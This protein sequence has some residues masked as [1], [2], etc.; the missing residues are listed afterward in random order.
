[1]PTF[2]RFLLPFAA[3]AGLGAALPGQGAAAATAPDRTMLPDAALVAIE[4]AD[5]PA[6]VEAMLSALGTLPED[7]PEGTRAQISLG[8]AGVAVALGATPTGWA[9]RVAGGGA[10]VGVMPHGSRQVVVA[11][12]RPGDLVEASSWFTRIVGN[13]HHEIVGEHLLLAS[14]PSALPALRAHLEDRG[15]RWREVAPAAAAVD[16][17]PAL[18]R[19]VVDLQGLRRT[20]GRSWPSPAALDPGQRLLLAPLAEVLTDAGWLRIAVAADDAVRIEAVADATAR[21]RASGALLVAAPRPLPAIGAGTAV[22]L[23]LERSV[24]ALFADPARVLDEDGV[25]SLQEFLSIADGLDGPGTSFVDDG[26]GGLGEPFDLLVF[27]PPPLDDDEARAPLLLPQFAL[28]T[29]VTGEQAEA[30]FTRM[31]RVFGTI[32]NAERQQ[33]QQRAFLIRARR[34]DDGGRGVVAESRAWSG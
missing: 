24:H 21:G 29:S 16:G 31:V 23:R 34:G 12:T 11:I 15:S 2:V 27:D 17:R 5:P 8:L 3:A 22:A 9:E 13:D 30:M 32:V 20:A 28:V 4:I 7:L 25:L 26:L 6:A 18:V 33:R 19:A 10:V 14:K 1:M